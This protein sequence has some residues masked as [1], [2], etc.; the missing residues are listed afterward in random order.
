[1]LWTCNEPIKE[2]GG[3]SQPLIFNVL[4]DVPVLNAPFVIN[5]QLVFNVL[6]F[7]INFNDALDF[8]HIDQEVL[9]EPNLDL[10]MDDEE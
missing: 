7:V 8:E 9:E 2:L 3:A 1:M 4:D 5:I 6:L 10:L